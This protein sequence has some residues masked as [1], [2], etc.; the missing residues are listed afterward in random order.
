MTEAEFFRGYSR[1]R[2]L[3]RPVKALL[4][5]LGPSDRKVTRSQIAFRARRGFAWVWLPQKWLDK[6]P[7]D[8]LVLSFALPRKLASRRIKEVVQPARGRF[9]HHL[10]LT[11]PSQLDAEVR[12]WLTE[13]RNNA[14]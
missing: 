10:V 13:A 6:V 9:M 11:D 2:A 12:R 14:L 3:Y 8:A 7:P 5:S 4:A 1:P